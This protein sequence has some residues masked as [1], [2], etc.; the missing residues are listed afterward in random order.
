MAMTSDQGCVHGPRR[1]EEQLK[2]RLSPDVIVREDARDSHQ[3]Y[4]ISRAGFRDYTRARVTNHVVRL[5]ENEFEELLAR[6]EELD[7]IG[8]LEA[9]RPGVIRIHADRAIQES[10]PEGVERRQ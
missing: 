6:L 4:G 1:C 5:S 2:F 9:A 7:W 3:S 8:V 10:D